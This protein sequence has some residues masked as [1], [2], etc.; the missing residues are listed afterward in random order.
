MDEVMAGLNI[1]HSRFSAMLRAAWRPPDGPAYRWRHTHD[2]QD[3]EIAVNLR[4]VGR[5]RKVGAA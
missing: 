1:W 2:G 3:H 4:T 5:M